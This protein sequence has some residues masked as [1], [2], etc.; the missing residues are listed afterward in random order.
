VYVEG[1]HNCCQAVNDCR[2]S[3]NK[4]E[5]LA[6]E[7]GVSLGQASNV[8]KILQDRELL[9]GK[10]GGLSLEQPISLLRQWTENYDY[11]KNWIRE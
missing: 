7:S 6:D 3:F 8:K 1:K 2:V 5:E 9:S 11:R 10:K 4:V